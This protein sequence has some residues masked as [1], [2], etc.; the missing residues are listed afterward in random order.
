MRTKTLLMASAMLA[1]PALAH[2]ETISILMESVPDTRF[3]QEVVPQF[4][5]ATGIEVEIEVVNYA[6]MHPKLVPQLVA[7]EGSYDVIVVDFYWVGE[8]T[9]AGWLQ[10]LDD[11]IAAAGMDTSVYVP[12]LMDLV[13]RVDGVTYMLPFYN[14]AMGLTYRQD[15]IDDP[16]NQAAFQ[17]EYGMPLQVPTSWQEYKDQVAFFTDKDAGFY[18][19]VNQ[20]LRP[21]PIAMEWSNYLFANGGRFYDDNWNPTL[22]TPEAVQALE[23]YKMMIEQF[24]PVGAASF[25]FDEA[26][27]VAAQGQAY[28]YL[29]YNMFRTAYDD[30]DQSAV[31]GK[32]ELAPVPNGGLNGA[33]GW[34]IP[35]SSPDPE[36]AW[37]FLQWVE[38]FDVAKQRA[39]LGGSPTRFDVFDDA[40][41]N[42]TYP[43]YPALRALL[44]TSHNFPVFTYTP[45]LVDIMGRELSL[46]VVG[47]KTAEEAL[48]T[49]Q[50]EFTE[51]ARRDGKIQ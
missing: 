29:T 27:N 3:I 11:R 28:S 20:G 35:V 48:A 41:L 51:L 24:G 23:D 13:G 2:A 9:K 12:S 50:E 17:A 44:D 5:E 19:V 49:I 26:F 47:D 40:E 14:Y 6:E 38:S 30:P 16:D 46:A 18:G 39:M 7:P 1:T 25:G 42:A 22:T 37:Q 15:L 43:Y 33:W 34:A 45:E 21:D 4:T 36:A 32:M 31:V 10:P 8:F